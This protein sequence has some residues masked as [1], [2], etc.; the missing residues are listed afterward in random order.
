MVVEIQRVELRGCGAHFPYKLIQNTSTCGT[1]L[2]ENGV[3]AEGPKIG[4]VC[5]LKLG[6]ISPVKSDLL[7]Y[8]RED[9]KA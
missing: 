3:L 4:I 7:F 6:K 1:V 2:T 5:Y 9:V 8:F